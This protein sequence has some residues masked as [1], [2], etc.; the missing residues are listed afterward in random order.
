MGR[1][2]LIIIPAKNEAK[3]IGQV[4]KKSKK[5]GT[6]IVI[7]DASSDDTNRISLKN[8][9]KIIRNKK[10]L[11]YDKSLNL[12]FEYARKKNFKQSN[13]SFLNIIFFIEIS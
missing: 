2:N 8:G 10:H 3:T 12:G 11:F 5:F 9:A 6:V 4:I 7:D 1:Y 13:N